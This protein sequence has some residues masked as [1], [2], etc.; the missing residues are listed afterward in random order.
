MEYCRHRPNHAI[1]FV[2]SKGREISHS[3]VYLNC[4]N[5]L[6]FLNRSSNKYIDNQDFIASKLLSTLKDSSQYTL[7]PPLNHVSSDIIWFQFYT[8]RSPKAQNHSALKKWSTNR[9]PFLK[10]TLEG[11]Y[12]SISRLRTS[13][14]SHCIWIC[15]RPLYGLI[16]KKIY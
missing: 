4:L 16:G 11:G 8:C 12:V 2:M 6:S 14:Y 1:L 3:F 5:L 13:Q 7:L 10:Q 9:K 15:F